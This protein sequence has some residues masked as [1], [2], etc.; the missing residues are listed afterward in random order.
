MKALRDGAADR[1]AR[2][3]KIFDTLFS[4]PYFAEGESFFLYN[5]F[6]SEAATAPVARELLARGKRVY[7]PRVEGSEMALVRYVGQ[8]FS[9]GRYGIA[10]PQGEAFAGFPQ[11]CLL[12]MLAADRACN[13]LGYGGGY[14]D[15]WLARARAAGAH[16]RKV[17]ICY[18]FQVVDALPAEAHDIPPD[19]VV[20]DEEIIYRR[21]AE[22]NI[23][24]MH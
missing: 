7:F 20:T 4:L 14:Y 22:G 6:G 15:R 13:R 19:A 2:D 8:P 17:G 10:E 11:V 24:C 23:L 16:V 1:P 5:A 9:F 21:D 3:A 12:P 18:A